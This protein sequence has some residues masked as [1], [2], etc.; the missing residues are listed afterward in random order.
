MP[1]LPWG[2][3]QRLLPEGVL[4]VAPSAKTP[5]AETRTSVALSRLLSSAFPGT[6]TS[7]QAKMQVAGRRGICVSL[8]VVRP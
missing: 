3:V 7:S 4:L 8:F 1:L 2:L 6:P 5:T